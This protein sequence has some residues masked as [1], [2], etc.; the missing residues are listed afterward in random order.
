MGNSSIATANAA[1][2]NS[3]AVQDA[4]QPDSDAALTATVFPW[5][6]HIAAVGAPADRLNA[7]WQAERGVHLPA[8]T[9]APHV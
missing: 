7:A 1:P 8:Q 6:E 2:G 4:V 5:E 3:N 9:N